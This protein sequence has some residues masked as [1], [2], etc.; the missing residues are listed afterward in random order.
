MNVVKIRK[1][2]EPAEK[3]T[4]EIMAYLTGKALFYDNEISK[5]RLVS[6]HQLNNLIKAKY[7]ENDYIGANQIL[8]NARMA[9][10]KEISSLLR[11][12]SAKSV[13]LEISDYIRLVKRSFKESISLADIARK[14][15]LFQ[16][17][18]KLNQLKSNKVVNKNILTALLTKIEEWLSLRPSE[19]KEYYELPW[20][21]KDIDEKTQIA[22]NKIFKYFKSRDHKDNREDLYNFYSSD[23]EVPFPEYEE[24]LSEEIHVRLI[25]NSKDELK[26]RFEWNIWCGLKVDNAKILLDLSKYHRDTIRNFISEERFL[27]IFLSAIDKST[28]EQELIFEIEKKIGKS[29]EDID[30][31]DIFVDSAFYYKIKFEKPLSLEDDE[32]CLGGVKLKEDNKSIVRKMILND[33]LEKDLININEENLKEKI[34]AY[35][36]KDDI[37]KIKDM[38]EQLVLRQSGEKIASFICEIIFYSLQNSQVITFTLPKTILQLLE[39]F[40]DSLTLKKIITSGE[41]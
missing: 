29:I 7:D 19:N 4:A 21:Y 24:S 38:Q 35:I 25:P 27:N 22:I 10:K 12:I 41:E 32:I 37:G 23:F 1:E 5:Y 3:K 6:K 18:K 9:S 33:I 17:L 39:G 28:T 13:R 26:L 14:N 31:Y 30:L 16:L 34:I 36:E 11:E 15:I 20:G 2:Y 8:E 40:F